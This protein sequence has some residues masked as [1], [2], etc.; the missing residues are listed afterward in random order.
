M[1][2]NNSSLERGERTQVQRIVYRAV[3]GTIALMMEERS[4]FVRNQKKKKNKK[5]ERERE[6]V[7]RERERGEKKEST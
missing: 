5:V 1:I 3:S 4:L 7:K 2:N 6:R